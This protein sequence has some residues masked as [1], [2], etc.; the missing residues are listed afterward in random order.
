[1]SLR[2]TRRV[3][4]CWAVGL[5]LLVLIASA[6]ASSPTPS[7]LESNPEGWIDLL[8]QPDLRDWQRAR[9][10]A[11]KP[12]GEVNPWSLTPDG[13]LRCEATGIHEM[14]LH[15]TPRTDGILHVEWRYVG[16]SPKPNSGVFVR[17]LPDCSSW[18]QAQLATSGL[19]MIFGYAPGAEGKPVRHTAGA[20][21][22]EL[23]RPAGEWNALE[24]TCRGH[25]I[26][27]WINGRVVAELTNCPTSTGQVGLEAEFHPVEFRQI[28]FLP[29]HP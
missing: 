28:K 24:L 5:G 2:L 22:P 15:R 3:A 6:S 9:F 11:N 20:R 27:L 17:T 25:V 10:P 12:L 18:F 19:G 4:C 8:A 29:L 23:Q 14:L 21:L 13:I 1:M 7:A 16:D 26:T